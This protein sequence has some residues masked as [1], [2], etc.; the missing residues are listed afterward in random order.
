MYVGVPLE[1]E[2]ELSDEGIFAQ[3]LDEEEGGEEEELPEAKVPKADV[4]DLRELLRQKNGPSGLF[5]SADA[6][7][8]FSEDDEEEEVVDAEIDLA[9]VDGAVEDIPLESNGGHENVAADVA[10]EL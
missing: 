7:I 6:F 2:I 8:P 4:G 9:E 10:P 5:S 3:E 1:T